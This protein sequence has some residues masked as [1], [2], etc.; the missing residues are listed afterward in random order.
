LLSIF[1]WSWLVSSNYAMLMHEFAAPFLVRDL[2]DASYL[3]WQ[4]MSDLAV[5]VALDAG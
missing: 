5:N 2:R 1:F 4:R 3:C